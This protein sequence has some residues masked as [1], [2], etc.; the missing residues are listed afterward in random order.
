MSVIILNKK[1]R[2]GDKPCNSRNKISKNDYIGL[3]DK[4]E[5]QQTRQESKYRNNKAV[6]AEVETQMSEAEAAVSGMFMADGDE[7]LPF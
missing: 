1:A 7:D 2:T 5:L 3:N 6:D 4:E